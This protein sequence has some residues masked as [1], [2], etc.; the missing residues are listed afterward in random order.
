MNKFVASLNFLASD[1]LRDRLQKIGAVALEQ[2][3]WKISRVPRGQKGSGKGSVRRIT[4]GE[5]VKLVSI[6]TT[7]DRH[8]AFP[9]ADDGWATLGEVDYVCAVSVDKHGAPQ[10][11][12]AHIIDAKE[13]LARFDRAYEA[14]IKAGNSIPLGQAMWVSL[15]HK[16]GTNPVYLV[17]AG[18]GR[19]ENF[20]PKL[21]AKLWNAGEMP[22]VEQ[23][24]KSVA[25]DV[26]ELLDETPL[27]IAEAKRRLAMTFGV[28]ESCIK[29]SI[30]A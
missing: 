4:R 7:K 27:T 26:Q 15:Y 2:E 11:G 30:E 14:R 10:E 8:I 20:P 28:E 23:E 17:G 24:Q 12:W 21:K 22:E 13:M 5:E 9:R 29:I 1:N 25:E 6:R 19:P 18:V 16:E 3:G